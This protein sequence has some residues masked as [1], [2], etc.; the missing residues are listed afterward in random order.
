M[1]VKMILPSLEEAKSPF[2]RPIKYSLF[3]PL[4]LATLAGYFLPEDEVELVDQHVEKLTLDDSPDLVCMQVY[5]TNAYRAYQIADSYR[6]RGVYV[7]MGGLHVTSLPQEAL[8]HADTVILGPGE[9]AFPRFIDDFRKKRPERCYTARER[10]LENIPP[11]RRDLIKR[12]KYFVPNSLVV[13][14]GCPHHCDFATRM[15][16]TEAANLSTLAGW[17]LP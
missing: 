12:S 15:P 17:I 7:A 3:P 13:S 5:V 10:S 8:L 1:K 9:E 2:W 4:G 11:V 14:R 6:S 16:F